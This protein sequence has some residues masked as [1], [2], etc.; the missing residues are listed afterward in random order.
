MSK[1]TLKNL[2]DIMPESDIDTIYKV[3][4]KFVP[5]DEPELDEIEAINRGHAEKAAGEVEK[6]EDIIWE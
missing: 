5:V 2:I 4:I 1:E 3:L 6:L